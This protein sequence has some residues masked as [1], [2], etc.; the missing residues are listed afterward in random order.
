MRGPCPTMPALTRPH[1]PHAGGRVLVAGHRVVGV[2]S[3]A[4]MSL[5]G[6]VMRLRAPV[7]RTHLR[8]DAEVQ[9]VEGLGAIVEARIAELL[10]LV[11]LVPRRLFDM[12]C[13]PEPE[14][15]CE[16]G[17]AGDGPCPAASARYSGCHEVR[18]ACRCDAG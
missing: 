2:A 7:I 9:A 17:G 11:A 10:G 18:T 12:R 4:A 15:R 5:P 8:V 6:G 13:A 16:P 14:V 1:E 3:R